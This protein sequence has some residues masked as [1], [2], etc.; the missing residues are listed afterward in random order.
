MRGDPIGG[1]MGSLRVQYDT[2][3]HEL[4]ETL[5]QEARPGVSDMLNPNGIDAS[6]LATTT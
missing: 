6:D 1:M 5:T 4:H 3:I 2:P